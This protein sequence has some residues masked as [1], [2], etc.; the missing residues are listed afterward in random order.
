MKITQEKCQPIPLLRFEVLM[1]FYNDVDAFLLGDLNKS[2]RVRGGYN[3]LRHFQ[4]LV[5][6]ESA[7]KVAVDSLDLETMRD[8]L[9]YLPPCPLTIEAFKKGI[10][11]SS[12]YGSNIYPLMKSFCSFLD[13][14]E[15]YYELRGEESPVDLNEYS[16]LINELNY[17]TKLAI[18]KSDIAVFGKWGKLLVPNI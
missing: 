13:S 18:C 15:M 17:P 9:T 11:A 5:P 4:K 10:Y 7:Y 1:S 16:K 8:K 3:R 2:D 14:Q 6:N 12:H